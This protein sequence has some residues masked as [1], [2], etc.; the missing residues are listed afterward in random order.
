MTIVP[1]SETHLALFGEQDVRPARHAIR[2][3]AESLP[4][5]ARQVA[6]ITLA[7][8]EACCNGVRYTAPAGDDPLVTVTTERGHDH[9]AVEIADH[10]EGF[11]LMAP[12]MPEPRAESGRGLALMHA[13]MD[14]VDVQ[15]TARGTRVRMIKYFSR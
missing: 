14:T 8:A 9:L 4:F 3:L 6:D 5:D 13:L 11:A 10:G 2:A 7:V 15:S 12:R 1:G